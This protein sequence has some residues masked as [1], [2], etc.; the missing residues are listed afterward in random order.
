M[1]ERVTGE[2]LGNLS[3]ESI[4]SNEP[5]RVRRFPKPWKLLGSGNYAAVFFHPDYAD[6]AVKVYAPGRP[7]LQEEAEVYRRLGNHHSYSE[8]Y[9]AGSNFLLLKRLNGVTFYNCIKR[10]IPITDQAIEDIDSA[11]EYARSRQLHPHDVHGKNVMIH[12][13][14]GLI[15]DVSDFLKQ[16]DCSM[17]KDFKKA[18]YRLY[19]P[20]ASRW[21]FPVPAIMLE[22][23]RKGYQLWRR[24]RKK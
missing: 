12:N 8:C 1:L 10:G 5:V 22:A 16:E 17:W 7:G 6:Y 19:R 4:Y 3:V 21:L 14:R 23:V 11:L 20:I 2:L 18:Y 13:G 24:R 9:Y 15:V